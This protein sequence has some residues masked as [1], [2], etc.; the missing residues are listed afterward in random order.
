[1]I[2]V[3]CI[4]LPPLALLVRG[5]FL[6]ALLNVPLSL[7]FWLPGIVHAVAVIARDEREW[8]DERL[9]CLLRGVPVPPRPGALPQWASA[10]AVVVALIM[11]G[12][13]V[14]AQ[15]AGESWKKTI[16]SS[17]SERAPKN[18]DSVGV[19]ASRAK[20][21]QSSLPPAGAKPIQSSLPPQ[22]GATYAEIEAAHGAPMVRN[23][24]TGWAFWQGWRG[25]F[26]GGKLVAVEVAP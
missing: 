5:K 10:L 12:C 21:I 16:Q 3:L 24:E 8:R 2:Y 26:E 15:I 1:M 4:L 19:S 7:V 22:P 9:A 11:A 20:T 17:F 25:L 18:A 6:H 23:A 13:M 14:Y